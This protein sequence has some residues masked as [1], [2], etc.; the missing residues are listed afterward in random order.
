MKSASKFWIFFLLS[1]L[2]FNCATLKPDRN[3]S[4]PMQKAYVILRTEGLEAK[5]NE[6]TSVLNSNFVTNNIASDI[7]YYPLGRKWNNNDIFSTAYNNNYDYIILIDQVAKFTIDG[8]TNVGGKYQIRSYPIKTS[9]PDWVDLGQKTCNISVRASIDKFSQEIISQIVPNYI[10]SKVAFNEDI[11][12]TEKQHSQISEVDYNQ[13]KS[14]KEIDIEIAELRKQLEIEKERTNKAVAEKKRLEKEY[15]QTLSF[16]KEKNQTILEGLESFKK[17]QELEE[18]KKD[19]L[20]Q[21][22]ELVLAETKKLENQRLNNERLAKVKRKEEIRLKELEKKAEEKRLAEAKVLE[23]KRLV[24]EESLAEDKRLEEVRLKEIE[25]KAKEEQ[26]AEEKLSKEQLEDEIML[27]RKKKREGKINTQMKKEIETF[28]SKIPLKENNG[29]VLQENKPK[30]SLNK[31]NKNP[32]NYKSKSVNKTFDKSN[33]LLIIRGSEEDFES[34]NKLKDNLELELLF[35]NI[36]A[37]TQT[38]NLKEVVNKKDG[39]SFNQPN[40]KYLIFIEQFDTLEDGSSNFSIS[41]YPSN[42][43]STW[44]DLEQRPFNLKDKTSLKEFSKTVLKSL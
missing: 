27:G 1:S 20:K 9:N 16:Q 24:E 36:K 15:E 23:E 41:V 5:I 30:T 2:L 39:L 8:K 18:I 7:N 38:F 14:S 42:S 22:E 32:S 3:E 33:A 34:F 6:L 29:I 43:N 28:E 44:K 17:E 12:N 37:T 13:L 31:K 35:T 25:K 40:Y 10:S 11:V 26:M 4:L 19:E 21:K